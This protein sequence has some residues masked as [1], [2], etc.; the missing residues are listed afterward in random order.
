MIPDM[1]AHHPAVQLDSSYYVNRLVTLLPQEWMTHGICVWSLRIFHLHSLAR[2]VRYLD[3]DLKGYSNS[4]AKIIQFISTEKTILGDQLPNDSFQVSRLSIQ[5]VL[6][7]TMYKCTINRSL[8]QLLIQKNFFTPQFRKIFVQ[9][10]SIN[11]LAIWAQS[12][13][14][15]NFPANDIACNRITLRRFVEKHHLS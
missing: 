8:V 10:S 7:R 5:Y 14:N 13:D 15:A 12:L 4:K 3:L 2:R 6:Y 1:A 11:I 9:A